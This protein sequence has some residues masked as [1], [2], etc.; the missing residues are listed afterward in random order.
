MIKIIAIIATVIMADKA[1]DGP[2]LFTDTL[3]ERVIES[4]GETF[5]EA[6]ESQNVRRFASLSAETLHVASETHEL[7]QEHELTSVA[8]DVD[9]PSSS[10]PSLSEEEVVT[11]HL[12]VKA[13]SGVVLR[14]YGWSGHE[15][16]YA[17]RKLSIFQYTWPACK[18]CSGLH[19]FVQLKVL[20]SSADDMIVMNAN[21]MKIEG[22]CSGNMQDYQVK[23]QNTY[24][25]SQSP[26]HARVMMTFIKGIPP[27]DLNAFYAALIKAGAT[28]VACPPM[29]KGN[30]L[31]QTKATALPAAPGAKAAVP[32]T[33]SKVIAVRAVS[34]QSGANAAK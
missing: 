29:T 24:Y 19:G 21:Q 10:S 26:G 16:G 25:D 22:G 32:Q 4:D 31:P 17:V 34:V 30:A 7:H 11:K 2:Q 12:S 6:E 23:I 18:E 13:W 15:P 14:K 9:L 27:K 8:V 5:Y 33:Q 3:A 1:E 28:R 20:G